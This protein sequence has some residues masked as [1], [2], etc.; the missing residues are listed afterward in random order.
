M[1]R[2]LPEMNVLTP[3]EAMEARAHF[4]RTPEVIVNTLRR[5]LTFPLIP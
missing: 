3:A 4:G 1:L 2:L 5:N